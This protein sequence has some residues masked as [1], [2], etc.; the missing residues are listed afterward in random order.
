MPTAIF[1]L[2]SKFIEIFLLKFIRNRCS[3]LIWYRS[4]VSIYRLIVYIPS[5]IAKSIIWYQYHNKIFKSIFFQACTKQFTLRNI[6]A[7]WKS[8]N[9][10]SNILIVMYAY[11]HFMFMNIE[12]SLISKFKVHNQFLSSRDGK[13]TKK[14]DVWQNWISFHNSIAFWLPFLNTLTIVYS[15]FT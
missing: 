14:C 11:I 2:Q 10:I 6:C 8:V 7:W 9:E 4:S 3:S 15:H 12:Q 5:V 13:N 1:Y